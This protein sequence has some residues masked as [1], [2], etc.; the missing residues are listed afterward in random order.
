MSAGFILVVEAAAET[1]G[2]AEANLSRQYS[3]TPS[4]T[5][6]LEALFNSVSKRD[7]VS[8]EFSLSTRLQ[9][10]WIVLMIASSMQVIASLILRIHSST[11]TFFKFLSLSKTASSF[12]FGGSIK[13][14]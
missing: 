4:L 12:C 13:V 1:T 7:W 10:P 11:G 5:M 8:K 9:N 2:L 6:S 14:S 3:S